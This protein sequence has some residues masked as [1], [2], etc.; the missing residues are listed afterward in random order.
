MSIAFQFA[1]RPKWVEDLNT[2]GRNVGGGQN[3]VSLDP[4]EMLASARASTGLDDFGDRFDGGAWHDAYTRF[5][6]ALLEEGELNTVGRLLARFEIL[7]CLE[8]RLR[9]EE[10]FR[11]HPEIAEEEIREPIFITGTARSG[12]S[13]LHELMDQDER[14]RTPQTWEVHYST[15]PTELATYATDPRIAPAD[16]EVTLWHEIAPEYKSMHE[17]GGRLPVECIFMMAH[18][19]RSDHWGG[20]HQVPSYA[21]WL[22]LEAD[23]RP[24]F[25]Y[26]R[27]MLQ[28]MQ[29]RCKRERWMLKAPSHLR[30]LPELFEVYPDARVILTHRDPCK[31]VASA[32]SLVSTLRHMRRDEVDVA[33]IAAQYGNGIILGLE[34]VMHERADGTLPNERFVDIRFADLMQD[35]AGSIRG[36]YRDLGL[37][38]P[39]DA[40]TAIRDYVAA[41]PR[42]KHGRHR[43]SLADFG[44]DETEIRARYAGYCEAYDVPRE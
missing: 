1:P 26:H 29:W 30:V 38:L 9:I 35:P 2:L 40:A 10:T 8:N 18:A 6:A 20:V 5:V 42:G 41:K 19:F 34:K 3:L 33:A 23:F 25:L 15:P 44:L 7:R 32:I 13:I 16:R 17:N 24:A 31:T 28:L 36:V 22:A 37:E 39:G 4:D 12:T 43:Y 14:N 27:R 21:A 11:L